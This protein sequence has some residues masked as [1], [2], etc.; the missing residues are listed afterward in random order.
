MV[1][2][3][4]QVFLNKIRLTKFAAKICMSLIEASPP[5]NSP[6]DFGLDIC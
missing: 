1:L 6:L 5:N 3:C 2:P 4:E